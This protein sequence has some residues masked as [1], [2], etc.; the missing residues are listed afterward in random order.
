MLNGFNISPLVP[1]LQMHN[2]NENCVNELLMYIIWKFTAFQLKA[3]TFGCALF[4]VMIDS[5][6]LS[7]LFD[8]LMS[9]IF[10]WSVCVC[11]HPR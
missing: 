11:S 6:H 8:L 2:N 5:L 10:F 7:R 4:V 1:R 9:N 3:Y